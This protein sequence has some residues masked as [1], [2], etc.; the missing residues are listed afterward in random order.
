MNLVF[1]ECSTFHQNLNSS[2]DRMLDWWITQKFKLMK[3]LLSI[4]SDIEYSAISVENFLMYLKLIVEKSSGN[5]L[6]ISSNLPKLSII[7]VTREN[8]PSPSPRR[9]DSFH[10]LWIREKYPPPPLNL[11]SN[12]NNYGSKFI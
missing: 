10:E 12:F 7:S 9:G 8:Y 1:L 2:G 11:M 6:L 5:I 3:S 4:I